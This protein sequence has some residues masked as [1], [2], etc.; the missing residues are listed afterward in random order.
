MHHQTP[1]SS[2]YFRRQKGTPESVMTTDYRESIPEAAAR[3]FSLPGFTRVILRAR[4][5]TSLRV[6][7][8]VSEKQWRCGGRTCIRDKRAT[9]DM[10]ECWAG[11]P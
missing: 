5:R 1:R 10:P 8:P 6:T 2:R 9:L 4:Q 11:S 7:P 3:L